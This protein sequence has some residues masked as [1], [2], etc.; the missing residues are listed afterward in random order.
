VPAGIAVV[1]RLAAPLVTGT[2]DPNVVEPPEEFVPAENCT[3]PVGAGPP[4][5]D[6]AT[7]AE[8]VTLVPLEIEAFEVLTL[9]A[10]P[11]RVTVTEVFSAEFW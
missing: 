8:S 3:V 7:V 2:A 6:A 4:D 5:F 10:E 1:V 9:V 11:S